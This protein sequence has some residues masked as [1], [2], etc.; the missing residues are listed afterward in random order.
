MK[1]K[2]AT[3]RVTAA[4]VKKAHQQ[5]AEARAVIAEADSQRE[6]AA[7]RSHVGKF[8]RYRNSY[9]CPQSEADYWWLYIAVAGINEYGNMSGWSF[10]TD[11]DGKIHIDPERHLSVVSLQQEISQG[12]FCGAFIDVERKVLALAMEITSPGSGGW[13]LLVNGQP[14]GEA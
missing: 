3:R 4:A 11:K 6:L 1:Q 12:E 10:Q 2:T 5:L 8:Y 14:R 7:N 9:S 13:Q